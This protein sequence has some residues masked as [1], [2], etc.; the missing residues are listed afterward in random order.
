M[1]ATPM[2]DRQSE[3]IEVLQAAVAERAHDEAVV[4][5]LA[6]LLMSEGAPVGSATVS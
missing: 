1:S 4:A 2:D 6:A 3:G 5:R